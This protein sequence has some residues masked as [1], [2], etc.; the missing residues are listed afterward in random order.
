M[1]TDEQHM[2]CVGKESEAPHP[3]V[4]IPLE[5][6]LRYVSHEVFCEVDWKKQ[7]FEIFRLF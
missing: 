2:P 1:M 5:V 7:L 4:A 6:M 3:A